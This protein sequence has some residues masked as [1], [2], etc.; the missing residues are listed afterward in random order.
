MGFEIFETLGLVE[1]HENESGWKV[2]GDP[3]KQ[4]DCDTRT[5]KT[6]KVDL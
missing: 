5:G 4:R 2:P 3:R 1:Y 6:H